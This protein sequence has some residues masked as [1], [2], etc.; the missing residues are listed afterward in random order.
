MVLLLQAMF[1]SDTKLEPVEEGEQNYQMKLN[2][3][4]DYI[5]RQ[6]YVFLKTRIHLGIFSFAIEVCDVQIW[7]NRRK[8]TP[9]KLSSRRLY[10]PVIPKENITGRKKLDI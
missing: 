3:K 4:L 9:R 2:T 8:Q 10:S 6:S 5:L 7:Y 1:T